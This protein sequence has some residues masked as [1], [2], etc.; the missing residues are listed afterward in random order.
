M[1]D[2]VTHLPRP[3]E[4]F[5]VRPLEAGRIGK[6]PEE[7]CRDDRENGAAIPLGFSADNDNVF[8]YLTRFVNVKGR[9]GFVVGNIEANFLHRFDGQ[10]IELAGRQTS[11]LHIKAM[12]A[13]EFEQGFGHLAAGTVV[14]TDEQNFAFFHVDRMH[15]DQ[16]VSSSRVWFVNG[17]LATRC[18]RWAG[19]RSQ[20]CANGLVDHVGWWHGEGGISSRTIDVGGRGIFKLKI[21]HKQ[22]ILIKE[23]A[24]VRMFK[25]S[26][27]FAVAKRPRC[28]TLTTLPIMESG[29]TPASATQ[30]QLF[31]GAL[32]VVFGDIG[33]SPLYTLRTCLAAQ[34][35][36]APEIAVLGSISLIFWVIFIVVTIK[37]VSFITRAD[38][39]GE[40][41]VF[42]LLGLLTRRGEKGRLPATRLS[43]IVLLMVAGAALLFGDG[44]ITPAISVLSAAEGLK[45]VDPRLE[46]LILPS[47]VAILTGLFWFQHKGTAAIGQ[48]F[49]PIM[50][51]WFAALG[52][53]GLVQILHYPEILRAIDPRL[54][55][56]RLASFDHQT[57]AILGG[58]VLAVTGVEALYAD[59][60]H[61]GRGAIRQAWLYLAMPC[62]VLN[63]FGQGAL[64]LIEPHT[65]NPFFLLAA[66]GPTRAILVG[67]S[68][69][70]TVIASQA[71]ISGTFSLIRQAVQLGFFP[72]VEVRHTSSEQAGQV[73][74]P[75]INGVLAIG[76][77]AVVLGFRSSENLAAAYGIAVTGAMMVT[78]IG[79]YAV[80]RQVW[81]WRRFPTLCLCGLFLAVDGALLAS[82]LPKLHTGGWLP[83][84]IGIGLFAVMHTWK[85]GRA[86][87]A[88]QLYTVQIPLD[89]IVPD[90]AFKKLPRVN[91]TAVFLSANKDAAPLALLHYMRCN[92]TL[93][94][95]VIVLSIETSTAPFVNGSERVTVDNLGEK[96]WRVVA[97]Y[98][99]MESPDVPYIIRRVARGQEEMKLQPDQ[100]YYIF[101]RENVIA[102]GPAPLWTWQKVFYK[103]LVRNASTARD[104][105]QIPPHQVIEMGLPVN[106]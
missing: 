67:L 65:Q 77:V 23:Y 74:L 21:F 51:L 37:Y 99:Y 36:V 92:Q 55:W 49:G 3:F 84:A 52:T 83:F 104:Y 68:I 86:Y 42:A 45:E 100:I 48:F 85:M 96:V 33:T 80:A 2:H 18:G 101:N 10:R 59:M 11:A 95:Q 1:G 20:R 6:G 34:P 78:T 9:L 61:F 63:Y 46:W 13:M 69:A 39:Q 35:E 71:L 91:G 58:V 32:G 73:Y 105:F 43:F 79:F 70:A 57:A 25:K 62:L 47:A 60:G 90:P 15:G 41:G 19:P 81:E 103:F 12:P 54:A 87:V 26:M 76:C 53:L 93:H 24:G 17:R 102:T 28:I 16:S 97:R 31:I 89:Q 8:E 88:R 75:F 22:Y 56:G 44:I 14:N 98:G 66:P 38:N 50:V 106:L 82:N 7:S 40:G 27:Q 5:G 94:K 29:A 30:R 4:F 72:R 64:C